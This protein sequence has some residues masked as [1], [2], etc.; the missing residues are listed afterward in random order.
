[1]AAFERRSGYSR[2]EVVG[3][4]GARTGNLE[5]PAD[6]DPLVRPPGDWPKPAAECEVIRTL[7]EVS[8]NG[9]SG[10]KIDGSAGSGKPRSSAHVL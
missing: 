2:G 8:P 7:E 1:M 6:K 4:T 5:D 9:L 3:R 10:Y